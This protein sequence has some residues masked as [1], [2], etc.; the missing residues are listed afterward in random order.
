MFLDNP[1]AT[2]K[3]YHTLNAATLLRT[4]MWP[5][6]HDCI[7]IIEMIFS[8]HPDLGSETLPNA[9]KEWLTDGSSFMREGKGL[10]GYA[11]TSHT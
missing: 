9:K 10:A 11:V 7:E 8:I 1:V 5:L 4:E 2:I 6:E 3:I